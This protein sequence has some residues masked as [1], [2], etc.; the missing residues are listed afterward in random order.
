MIRQSKDQNSLLFVKKI[1]YHLLNKNYS[2]KSYSQNF[3]E[4]I[5]NSEE[6]VEVLSVETAVVG[7]Q[8]LVV[9]GASN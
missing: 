8:N 7:Q 5:Q 6:V 4:F 3:K 9:E 2:Y 1:Y